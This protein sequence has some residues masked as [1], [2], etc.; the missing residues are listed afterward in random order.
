MRWLKKNGQKGVAIVFTAF[1]LPLIIGIT[2]LAVDVGNLYLHKSSLQNATDAAVLAGGHAY[3]EDGKNDTS[4]AQDT[5]NEY[6]EKNQQLDGTY[7]IH[8][9]SYSTDKKDSNATRITLVGE[10][11]VPM[12]FLSLFGIEKEQTIRAKS[13]AKV[14]YVGNNT[15][16][17]F[18]YA[19]I[20]GYKGKPQIKDGWNRMGGMNDILNAIVFH[21]CD[22]DIK[23]NVHVNGPVYLDDN[24]FITAD[25]LS[26]LASK[27]SE[28]WSN[29]RD[30]YG[31]HYLDGKD[32]Y[33]VG[34]KQYFYDDEDEATRKAHIRP[35]H[36]ND[37][38]IPDSSQRGYTWRYYYRMSNSKKEDY[39]G[40]GS[41]SSEVDI[42]YSK[43]NPM[44]SSLY[45]MV[46]AYKAMS[47]AQ[48]EAAHVYLDADSNKS[49]QLNPSHTTS[50]Y[51]GLTC[52]DFETTY[53]SNLSYKVWDN[54][55]KI[56][57]VNGDLTVNIPANQKPDNENDHLLLVS[58]NGNISMQNSSPF[59]GYVY[60]PN[61]TVLIDGSQNATIYGSVV[62]KSI[63][64]TT[65]GQKIHATHK[66]FTDNTNSGKSGGTV[67]VSLVSD[68]DE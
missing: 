13:T 67:T 2:G 25:V 29:Y 12:H 16:R 43:N 5:V 23:G 56:V 3:A 36:E 28:L 27:D 35:G 52:G 18:E 41:H 51:P 4:A 54:V 15:P 38:K 64:L 10:E 39:T 55:Y 9:L 22:I 45:D 7:K 1:L 14:V 17:I 61:G 34:D 63:Y 49:Y 65:G 6:L 21:S 47:L 58:L 57:I 40:Q 46:Q 33:W 11:T 32:S 20:G 26:C 42:S 31:E 8:D 66:T 59:Y 48:R 60:A 53:P 50:I 62:A 19:M 30:N 44:T 68:D 37:E 24:H